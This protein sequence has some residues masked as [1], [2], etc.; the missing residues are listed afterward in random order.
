MIKVT[1]HS[2]TEVDEKLNHSHNC[3]NIIIKMGVLQAQQ[4]RY[5]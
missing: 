1:F 2:D 5:L 3:V 4:K